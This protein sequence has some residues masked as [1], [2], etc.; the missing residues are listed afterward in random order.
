M[1]EKDSSLEIYEKPIVMN[2]D[3]GVRPMAFV[4]PF[5]VAGAVFY[6]VGAVVQVAVA[7]ETAYA[8]AIAA[9]EGAIV[10]SSSDS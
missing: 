2:E 7:L 6:T 10:N 8:L 5:L 4:V 3:D 1:S 9:T